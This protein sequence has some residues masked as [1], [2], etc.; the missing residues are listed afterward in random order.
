MVRTGAAGRQAVWAQSGRLQVIFGELDCGNCD[1]GCLAPQGEGVSVSREALSALHLLPRV[2]PFSFG[3]VLWEIGSLTTPYSELKY[4]QIAS[5]VSVVLWMAKGLIASPRSHLRSL[6][7][8]GYIIA[9]VIEG[10]RPP[11]LEG[12]DEQYTELM[13]SCWHEDSAV[14]PD[15]ETIVLAVSELISRL[16][17]PKTR[18]SVS[19]A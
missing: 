17:Q 18:T 13:E 10:L 15:F 14:R 4:I 16:A 7:C 19:S 2:S 1:G 8:F 12:C 5:K 11:R 3:I 6:P 9:Q